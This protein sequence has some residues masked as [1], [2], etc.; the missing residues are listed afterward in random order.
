MKD[1]GRVGA[2]YMEKTLGKGVMSSLCRD[3][4]ER[5]IAGRKGKSDYILAWSKEKGVSKREKLHLP[6]GAWLTSKSRKEWR[7]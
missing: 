6:Y 1:Q 5:Q 2:W 4:H 7:G 3:V